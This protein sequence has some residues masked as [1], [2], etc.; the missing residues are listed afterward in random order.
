MNLLKIMLLSGLMF[1][2]PLWANAQTDNAPTKKSR[3]PITNAQNLKKEQIKR[4][5]QHAVQ[6]REG[7]L[8][9]RIQTFNNKI[10]ALERLVKN[11][12]TNKRYKK[13][14]EETQIEKKALKKA[15]IRAYLENYSYSELL[16][17]PDTA[18]KSFFNG[19]RKG[20]FLNSETFEIDNSIELEEKSFVYLTYIG[21]PP[22]ATSNGKRSVLIANAENQLISPPFPYAT[23]LYSFI[24][25]ILGMSDAD[26]IAKAVIKQQKELDKFLGKVAR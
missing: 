2:L 21:E 5:A 13:Q 23:P 19:V 8:I 15:T 9:V 11:H 4:A 24:Q 7:V 10:N 16:F 3:N 1:V 17:M 14:L 26:V 20:I 25:T 22:V 6:L 18:A 12:P